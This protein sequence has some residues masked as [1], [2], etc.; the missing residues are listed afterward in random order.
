MTDMHWTCCKNTNKILFTIKP[1]I[2]VFNMILSNDYHYIS[3]ILRY[4]FQEYSEL[5]L[6]Y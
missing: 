1:S 2:P 5:Y 6:V 4:D 3:E